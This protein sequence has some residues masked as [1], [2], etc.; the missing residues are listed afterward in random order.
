M[1]IRVL[2]IN[3][4]KT[5]YDLSNA[6][7]SEIK[8]TTTR[9]GKA[10]TI[11]FDIIKGGQMSF[12]EGDEVKIFVDKKLYIK[13]Y[14]F[15]KSKKEDVITLTCYDIL[16]YLQYKQSYNFTNMTATKIIK[17]I[18]NEFKLPIS[19][20]ADTS[21]ILPDKVYEDKTL[22]D[23]IT[24]VLMQT[25][26]KTKKVFNLYDNAGKLELKESINMISNYVLGNKSLVNTYTYKT[27]IEESYNYIKLVKPNKATGKGETYVAL[28][29]DKIKKWGHLQFY[30]KV[31]ENLNDAQIREMA[32]NYLKHYAKTNRNLKL[33][34][35]GLKEIR[36]GSMILIDIP[37]LGDIDLKKILLIE[38]CTHKLSENQHTMSLEMNVIND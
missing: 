10:S 31:D 33:E 28:D 29:N 2:V 18:A 4:K 27:S 23:I 26:V 22:L 24:D 34:C 19:N 36:A 17:Q 3:R 32:K 35:M 25:T 38:K 15:S 7:S 11:T 9:T 30:K 21:Y 13:C 14:I 20:I 5:V 12:H 6:I 16:R 8:Y 1:R 37:A